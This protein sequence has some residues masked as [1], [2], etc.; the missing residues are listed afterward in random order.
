MRSRN[1]VFEYDALEGTADN[2][3]VINKH[4][5]AVLS[6]VLENSECPGKLGPAIT[7]KNGLLYTSHTG[8]ARPPE[9]A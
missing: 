8:S 6:K 1:Y 3:I 4:I 2:T 5:I 7:D 9:A